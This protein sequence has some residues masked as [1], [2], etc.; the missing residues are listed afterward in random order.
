[1]KHWLQFTALV[2][3]FADFEKFPQDENFRRIMKEYKADF[4]TASWMR[5]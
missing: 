1:M 2:R 3:K 5:K 4:R